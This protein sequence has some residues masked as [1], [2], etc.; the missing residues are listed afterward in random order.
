[1]KIQH[2]APSLRSSL[3]RGSAREG[4]SFAQQD[5]A[6]IP[7]QIA[8]GK[9]FRSNKKACTRLAQRLRRLP[10]VVTV[11]HGEVRTVNLVLR[12]TR[13]VVKRTEAADIF[14]E[15]SALY[16]SILVSVAQGRLH[17]S[18]QGTSLGLHALERLFERGDLA[19]DR[20]KLSAVDAEACIVFRN[21]NTGVLIEEHDNGFIPDLRAGVWA[22]T[23]TTQRNR[24]RF[25]G[26]ASCSTEADPRVLCADLSGSRTYTLFHL[27]A[28][29]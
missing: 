11:T 20:P 9:A 21:V 2:T 17:F 1:M 6:N 13:H 7:A 23:G 29:D 14:G 15:T 26:K 28:L 24:R 4:L 27:A 16:T 12:N 3:R 22:G 18:I 25:G 8:A 5:E 10:D 19:L